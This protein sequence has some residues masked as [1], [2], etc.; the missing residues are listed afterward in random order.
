MI[1]N[2]TDDDATYKRTSDAGVTISEQTSADKVV[3]GGETLDQPPKPYVS[4][5]LVSELDDESEYKNVYNQIKGYKDTVDKNNGKVTGKEL[6]WQVISET[7]KTKTPNSAGEDSFGIIC[8]EL[9]G[10][11]TV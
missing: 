1:V 2:I 5:A 3:S 4:S 6:E 9:S 10:S 7:V 8:G 11:G